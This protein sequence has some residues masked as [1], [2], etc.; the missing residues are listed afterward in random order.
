MSFLLIS[1]VNKLGCES[2]NVDTILTHKKIF[3]LALSCFCL[4]ASVLRAHCSR[5]SSTLGSQYQPNQAL[6]QLAATK[7]WVMGESRSAPVA[8]VCNRFQPP[9]STGSF[10]ARRVSMVLQSIACTSTFMSALRSRL[11]VTSAALWG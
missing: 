2:V 9:W 7:K 8:Q 4:A 6:S 1:V 11:A 10:L 3:V 5:S